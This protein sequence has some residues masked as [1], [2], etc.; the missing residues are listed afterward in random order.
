MAQSNF[1]YLVKRQVFPTTNGF[2]VKAVNKF[3]GYIMKCRRVAIKMIVHTSLI[4]VSYKLTPY[5]FI[6]LVTVYFPD[7]LISLAVT[8]TLHRMFS[9][10]VLTIAQRCLDWRVSGELVT[11]TTARVPDAARG[12]RRGA[13]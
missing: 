12:H 11:V 4:F 6:G 1:I 13:A 2:F 3:E 8:L 5:K 9:P 10:H 7:V